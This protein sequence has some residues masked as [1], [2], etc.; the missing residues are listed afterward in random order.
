LNIIPKPYKYKILKGNFILTHKTA[1]LIPENNFEV[2]QIANKFNSEINRALG[3]QLKITSNTIFAKVFIKFELTG[4]GLGK[5]GYNLKIAPNSITIS[6]EAINGLFYGIQTIYQLLPN[7]IP[8]NE[9]AKIDCCEIEDKPRFLW[10][11]M[12]L[13]VS[14]HFFDVSFIKRYIDFLAIFKYNVFHWH[15]TD[16]NGWRIEI[17]KY[18]RLTEV[19]AWRASREGVDWRDRKPQQPN[20]KTGYGGFYNQ[21]EIKEIVKYAKERQITIIPEIEMPG[22]TLEVL[23][24]YPE[25]GCTGGPYHVATGSYW[26]NTDIF[27]AGND[28]V[29]TFLQ[30]VLDE[31]LELFPSKIIHIGG[32]EANKKQWKK[33]PKCLQ[34]MREENLKNVDELQSWFIK[35]IEKYLLKK[36]LL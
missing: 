30:N 33:C 10:R 12:H 1:I 29:F 27:C 8:N 25:L 36:F 34:R 31:I 2:L 19:G 14:R 5:E 7:G 24:A 21:K 23:A 20:E 6:A 35:K 13:D 11:G 4:T 9:P 3:F 26:P 28:E 15:L 32:D 17:K 18:P 16:D 22:H